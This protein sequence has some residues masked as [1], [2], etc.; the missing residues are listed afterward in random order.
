MPDKRLFPA[1]LEIGRTNATS[2]ARPCSPEAQTDTCVV[3]SVRMQHWR[4]E[5]DHHR[6]CAN[7]T[8][9]RAVAMRVADWEA[10]GGRVRV[11]TS[12]EEVTSSINDHA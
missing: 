10:P 1:D 12:S 11:S 6:L 4:Q 2:Y 3:Q 8:L 7:G 5:L 9:V